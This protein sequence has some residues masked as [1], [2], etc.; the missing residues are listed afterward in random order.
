[1]KKDI[2]KR[3][4]GRLEPA[5]KKDRK[6]PKAAKVVIKTAVLLPIILF[7]LW[8]LKLVY[9]PHAEARK[10]DSLAKPTVEQGIFT[11][12][13]RDDGP[14]PKEHFHIVDEHIAQ[15]EPYHPICQECHGS[16]PH[17]KE[18][19]VRS[20]LNFHGGFLACMVCHVRKAPDDKSFSFVW[21]N[22]QT[23]ATSM[24]VEGGFGK[25]P[26]KIF[27][28]RATAGRRLEIIHPVDEKAAEEF[29]RL[30]DQFSAD[31]M[32]KAKIK[33]HENISKK[34]V[35]CN[36]CHKKEGYFDFAKLG[37]PA[38]RVDHLT[39]TEITGMIEKYETFYM[40]ESIDFGSN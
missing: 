6:P 17:S 22:R 11:K 35:F 37:F 40:P 34:P 19:K 28:I 27:P 24:K 31:Q 21:V 5:A 9:F 32:A 30:K 8:L 16:Y 14:I 23:G 39:S 26:A 7:A 25:Y 15:A 3:V 4:V 36:E 20:I 33:L 12:I 2:I 10:S 29:M 13:L 1:M 18:K 38:N